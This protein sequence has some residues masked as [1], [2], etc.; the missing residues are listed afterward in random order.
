MLPPPLP[1]VVTLAETEI[2]VPKLAGLYAQA[3]GEPVQV[4]PAVERRAVAVFVKN[5]PW[6]RVMS[7]AGEAAG[8]RL[9]R[10]KDRL[11]IEPTRRFDLESLQNDLTRRARRYAN[12]PTDVK[13]GFAR[14]LALDGALDRE[15]ARPQCDPERLAE[16]TRAREEVSGASSPQRLL[17]ARYLK[18]GGQVPLGKTVL[19]RFNDYVSD[20]DFAAYDLGE[21]HPPVPRYAAFRCDDTTI[22]IELEGEQSVDLWRTWSTQLDVSPAEET[23]KETR[24][25]LA[26]VKWTRVPAPVYGALGGYTIGD[27]VGW[28]HRL[29]DRPAVGAAPRIGLPRLDENLVDA[30]IHGPVRIHTSG[31]AFVA[32]TAFGDGLWPQDMER[33]EE[34]KTP[35]IA[36]LA[37]ACADAPPIWDALLAREYGQIASRFRV[38]LNSSLSVLRFLG[39]I[40]PTLLTRLR[41]EERIAVRSLDEPAGSAVQAFLI[42]DTTPKKAIKRAMSGL[43]TI[44]PSFGESKV[45]VFSTETGW[46]TSFDDR[47][48]VEHPDARQGLPSEFVW[49]APGVSEW[50]RIQIGDE[51]NADAEGV[52]ITRATGPKEVRKQ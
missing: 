2:A 33:L 50:F 39:G 18:R 14:Y 35:T 24:D 6:E 9:V 21:E 25:A 17:F 3:V 15:Q 48:L 49:E 5:E 23:T 16:L 37:A 20:R 44:A 45:T 13:S 30:L 11:R 41:T 22:D 28:M 29:T 34:I 19:L 36:S 8:F 52:S 7:L 12:P 10:V 26:G 51:S 42:E 31:D 40:P 27:V 47:T 4:L 43:F 1:L 38:D 32:T 46:E